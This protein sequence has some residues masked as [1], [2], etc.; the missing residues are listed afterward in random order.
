MSKKHIKVGKV[1]DYIKHSLIAIAT[2][3]TCVSISTFASLARIPIGIASSAI[4]LKTCV[5]TAGN[6][7]YKSLIKKKRKKHDKIVLL[8]KSQLNRIE[9]LISKALIDSNIGH[10]ELVL[11]NN[12]LKEFH[13]MKE[14]IKNSN[15][16]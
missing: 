3:T 6:K 10:D 13:D 14:E 8:A 1:L 16:K 4:G 12:A 15:D 11:I 2:I 9:I 7:K 5:T